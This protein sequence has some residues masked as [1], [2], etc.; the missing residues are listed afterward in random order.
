MLAPYTGT[1]TR[2][3]AAHLL[4]RTQS[5]AGT[6]EVDRVLS[7]G[8]EVTVGRLVT[9]QAEGEEFLATESV[10][11]QSAR[12]SRSIGALKN[13]WFYRMLHTANP[14]AEKMVLFWHNHFATSNRKVR[15]A[16]HMA[17]QNQ[18]IREHCLGRFDRLL[19]GMARDVA[20]LKWLDSNANRKRQP[21]ENF[22]REVMELFTLG[23]GNYTEHDIKE[24]ARAF[25]GWHLRNEK[26]WLNRGQHD[27]G[28][29]TVFGRSGEFGGE[30]ILRLCLAHEACPRLLAGKLL[31]TF[32][33][34]NPDIPTT[35][36]LAASIRGHAF[37]M[38]RVMA[39]LL[40]SEAFFAPAARRSL[41]KSPAELVLG[42]YR[43][44]GV[45]AKL[46]QSVQLMADLGQSLFEPPTVKGWEGGRLW[47]NAT[48]ML[49]RTN[50]AAELVA[51]DRYG[52]LP[53]PRRGTDYT[54]LLLGEAADIQPPG[55]DP[56]GKI[57]FILSTPEYQM[58]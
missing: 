44:L 47:I 25:S 27:G 11:S 56:L 42:S 18:L 20:M 30:D 9:P 46:P 24:A 54:R 38:A 5:G 4:W 22:A 45:R 32:V 48:S 28:T 34:P 14:L 15:S 51:G 2:G 13:W 58:L 37:D 7:D 40:C 23:V 31:K 19:G 57:Q 41:I 1:W 55:R 50:F 35:E 43:A 12:S 26:F 53:K 21:N 8:L 6:G 10:L 29:K 3:E 33:S 39:E 36:A 52:R 49:Q 17:V 16:Q